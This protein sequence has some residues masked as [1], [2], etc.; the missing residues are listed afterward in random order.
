MQQEVAQTARLVAAQ[1]ALLALLVEQGPESQADT[2]QATV[3]YHHNEG[4][5]L[6]VV[7]LRS[8]YPVAGEG[9]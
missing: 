8:G 4:V 1:S 3:R 9:L 7:Y 6:D 2:V 5:T